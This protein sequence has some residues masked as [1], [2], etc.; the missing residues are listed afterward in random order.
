[1]TDTYAEMLTLRWGSIAVLSRTMPIAVNPG[2]AGSVRPW[3]LGNFARLLGAAMNLGKL[4]GVS[5]PDARVKGGHEQPPRRVD[6][7]DDRCSTA[8]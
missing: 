8:G 6:L 3:E 2:V 1:M 5:L 4:G 7:P